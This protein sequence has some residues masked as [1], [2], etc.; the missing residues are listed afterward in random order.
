MPYFSPLIRE[1]T[2]T[3]EITEGRHVLDLAEGS[4]PSNPASN[5]W[6]VYPKTDGLYVL[7]DAGTETGPLAA[8]GSGPSQATQSAL[9][10][11]TNED[12]Y[13]PPDLI[14]HSP[15]VAKAWIVLD[16]TGTISITSSYNIDSVV[17]NGT[18]DYTINFDVDFSSGD[19][20]A[21]ATG[22]TS[23]A[24][25]VTLDDSGGAPAAGSCQVNSYTGGN[26]L[27]D[28]NRVMFVFFG[29]Q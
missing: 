4:K 24:L 21:A 11:E 7:D 28:L 26:V 1:D 3:V 22:T 23:G 14:K 12:T 18:G 8:G 13:A 27:T 15:G 17:D 10:A 20:C 19:Y 6:R 16:G 2:D 5:R 9:E 25:H 29:D